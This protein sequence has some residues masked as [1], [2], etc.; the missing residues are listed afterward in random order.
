MFRHCRRKIRKLAALTAASVIGGL[1]LIA[2]WAEPATNDSYMF[3]GPFAEVWFLIAGARY[4][5]NLDCVAR[6]H[7]RPMVMRAQDPIEASRFLG[8]RLPSCQLA[9]IRR[10]E[11]PWL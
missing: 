8:D 3:R 5:V 11:R 7:A 4:H 1:M 2:A 10:A 6:P 9:H